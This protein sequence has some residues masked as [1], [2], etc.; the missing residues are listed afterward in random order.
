MVHTVL[1]G[2]PGMYGLGG[3]PSAAAPFG[4]Y[5]PAT[6]PSDLV[7][8]YVHV[9]GVTSQIDSVAPAAASLRPG[10]AEPRDGDRGSARPGRG[11][12]RVEVALGS[13]LGTRSGD[14]GGDA[15]LGVYA[16]S[17]AGWAW[18]DAELTVD[19]SRSCSPKPRRSPSIATGSRTCGRSTS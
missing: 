9:N 13:F 8:Q 15:N 17:D 14:K 16:R 11:E 1:A 2:I 18:L 19:D 12:P 5:R 3:G 4:V 7:P 10:L 6:I